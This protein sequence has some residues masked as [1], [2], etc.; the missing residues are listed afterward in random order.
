[1]Y[2]GIA[3]HGLPR[4]AGLPRIVK[5]VVPD[6]VKEPEVARWVAEGLSRRVFRK[7]VIESLSEGIEV[8]LERAL[9]EFE[10]TRDEVWKKIEKEYRKKGLI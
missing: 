7:L 2:K 9:E 1:M 6:E 10:R 4:G 8:D 5:I 3:L